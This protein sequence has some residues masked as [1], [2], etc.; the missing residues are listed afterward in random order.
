VHAQEKLYSPPLR[1]QGE[2]EKTERR[3]QNDFESEIS[4]LCKAYKDT[5]NEYRKYLDGK[6]SKVQGDPT[7]DEINEQVREMNDYLGSHGCSLPE[8]APRPPTF[9]AKF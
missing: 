6:D 2:R 3:K 5:Y 1:R 9:S 4:E 7:L 8:F